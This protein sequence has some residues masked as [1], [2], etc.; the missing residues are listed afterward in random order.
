M[1]SDVY[2]KFIKG[3]EEKQGMNLLPSAGGYLLTG[4]VLRLKQP[5]PVDHQHANPKQLDDKFTDVV[6][7]D[8]PKEGHYLPHHPVLKISATTPLQIV[9]NRSAKTRQSSVSLN[10]YLQTAPSLAQRLYDLLF[11]FRIGAYT[12]TADISKAFLRVGLQEEDRNYTKFL[13]IKDP[14]DPN[15]ELITYRFAS[16][17]FGAMSLPFLLQATL[18]T[19]LKKSNSPN[20]TEI[21]NNLY[22]DNFQG[23]TSSKSKLLNIYHEANRELMEKICL[24]SRGSLQQCQIKST[25]R[26]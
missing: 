1:G 16:V 6:T 26:N 3:K 21:S 2:H 15:S 17:L 12:Y 5:A 10:D 18:D 23:T 22:V 24:S 14:N 11:K 4:P 19:N 9:F 7:N 20:K 13:W 25:D 8:N